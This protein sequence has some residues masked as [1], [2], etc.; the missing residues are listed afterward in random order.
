MQSSIGKVEDVILKI[1]HIISM[2]STSVYPLLMA[3]LTK[4]IGLS[5]IAPYMSVSN[6]LPTCSGSI[7]HRLEIRIGHPCKL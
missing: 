2:R 6:E 7:P 4:T 1:C 3:R 5:L